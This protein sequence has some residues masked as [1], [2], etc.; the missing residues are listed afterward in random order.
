MYR[1]I[2][3]TALLF[4]AELAAAVETGYAATYAL[5]AGPV[6]VGKME[7]SFSRD[8]N[9]EYRFTSNIRATGLVSI[10]N[11]DELNEKSSGTY[12]SGVF[13]PEN[14]TYERANKS[15]PR[16]VLTR[17]DREKGM[18]ETSY[19]GEQR[20]T[21]LKD[22]M[23]DT[24]VYQAALMDDLAAGKTILSYLV[25]DRGREKTYDAIVGD[26]VRVE[27]RAGDFDTV[28]VVR[29]R[30]DDQRRTIFWC[31][32]ALDYVPVRVAHRDKKGKETI[33]TLVEY[34]RIGPAAQASR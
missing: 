32:P 2:A 9:G 17:F 16:T 28:E 7:R 33:V 15:K 34:E 5:T 20:T 14:Y 23:L 31:A 8:S 19:N 25:V 26:H 11:H 21:P 30:P 29:E 6:T 22:G 18:V 1:Y 12:R 10:F 3:F 24:L 4:T 13:F 27:T